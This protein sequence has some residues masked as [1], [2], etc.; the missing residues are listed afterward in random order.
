MQPLNPDIKYIYLILIRQALIS[1][2]GLFQRHFDALILFLLYLWLCWTCEI[3]DA[4]AVPKAIRPF[5]EWVCMLIKVF[6][7]YMQSTSL[8]ITQ[9]SSYRLNS[10]VINSNPWTSVRRIITGNQLVFTKTAKLKQDPERNSVQLHHPPIDFHCRNNQSNQQSPKLSFWLECIR[11]SF[12]DGWWK[13]TPRKKR[14]TRWEVTF[15]VVRVGGR[16]KFYS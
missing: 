5:P 6:G 3:F 11:S 2:T 10:F 14:T 8:I 1:P 16:R 9:Q 12:H 15:S 13:T 4:A 7:E